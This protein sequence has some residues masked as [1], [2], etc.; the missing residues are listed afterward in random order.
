M[1]RYSAADLS[2]ARHLLDCTKCRAAGMGVEG[3]T[4][5]LCSMCRSG[6]ALL[7][8]AMRDEQGRRANRGTA[9]RP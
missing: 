3:A 7:T 4:P 1:T 5:R 2:L 6:L 9:V 8:E